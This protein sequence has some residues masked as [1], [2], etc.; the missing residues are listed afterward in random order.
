MPSTVFVAQKADIA[1]HIATPTA[2][3]RTGLTRTLSSLPPTKLVG[4]NAIRGAIAI[5]SI[6]NVVVLSGCPVATTVI[7]TPFVL[8]AILLLFEVWRRPRTPP[9]PIVSS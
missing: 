3:L 4:L 8:R 7:R 5:V 6:A 2:L 1:F 9:R